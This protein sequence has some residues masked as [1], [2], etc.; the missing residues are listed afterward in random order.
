MA[1][2]KY[3]TKFE[4]EAHFKAK[5]KRQGKVRQFD[6][7][8]IQTIRRAFVDSPRGVKSAVTLGNLAEQFGCSVG[9]INAV[10]RAKGAYSNTFEG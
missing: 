9:T 3:V 10:L 7:R 2:I 1:R 5:R 8:Q 6:L 4:I